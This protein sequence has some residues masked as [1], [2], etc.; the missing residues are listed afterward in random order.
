MDTQTRTDVAESKRAGKRVRTTKTAEEKIKTY[1]LIFVSARIMN[2]E[3]EAPAAKSPDPGPPQSS[4]PQPASPAESDLP[5]AVPVPDKPGFVTSPYAP[6][7]GFVDV[8]GFPAG[9]K[10][11]CPY[12]GKPFVIP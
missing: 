8:R 10:I 12:T 5:S 4:P 2:P 9:T 7:A 6:R 3:I 11:K 1:L